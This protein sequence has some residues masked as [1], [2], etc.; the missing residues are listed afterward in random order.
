M[1]YHLCNNPSI[2]QLRPIM[3]Y[4]K[5]T[6]VVVHFILRHSHPSFSQKWQFLHVV[7]TDERTDRPKD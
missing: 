6:Q 4:S 5:I 3:Y 2:V 1:H 7:K